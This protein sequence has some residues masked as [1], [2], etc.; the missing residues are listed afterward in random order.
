MKCLI[1]EDD[2][3]SSRVL[4]KMIARHGSSDAVASGLG[5]LE[6]FRQAHDALSPYDLILMDIMIPE[7]DGL[8]S[9]LDIRKMET[10]MEI[11]WPQRVAIVMV[12]S[13]DDPHIV[14][15]ALLELDA[16]SYLVKPIRVQKLDDE[17][18]ALKLIS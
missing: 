3:V 11:P 13:L 12:T 18:R 10:L 15:K 6:L 7:I 8:Q 14:A 4:E 5:A 17:L 2:K 9:V 1:V 16:S